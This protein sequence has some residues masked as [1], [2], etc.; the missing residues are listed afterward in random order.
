MPESILLLRKS[1]FG[2]K[3]YQLIKTRCLCNV[4]WLPKGSV[5]LVS[6]G[7]FI[8]ESYFI[9]FPDI[10]ISRILANDDKVCDE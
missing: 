3:I 7:N 5:F 8:P 9:L 2:F 4:H 6:F 10:K 1:I